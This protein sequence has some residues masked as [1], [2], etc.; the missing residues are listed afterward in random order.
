MR[1]MTPST[2]AERIE[3]RYVPQGAVEARH[4]DAQA[5]V[6]TYDHAS[7]NLCAIGYAGKAFRPSFNLRF[8]DDARRV[9]Y[10]AE[11]LASQRSSVT[12]RTARR[13][14]KSAATHALQ[15]GDILSSSWGYEQTNVDFFQVVAVVSAKSVKL[16]SIKQETVETG[17]MC[18]LTTPLK[19]QFVETAAEV[20]CRAEGTT[21]LNVAGRY[22]RSAS[23]WEGRGMHISWYA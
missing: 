23:K 6:Y 17:S 4:D 19:D 14:Q 15:C 20:L 22:R 3:A 2:A 5:V 18:G 16:R 8:R 10:I 7:G 21:V 11:W 13:A 1:R 12:A 9:Q